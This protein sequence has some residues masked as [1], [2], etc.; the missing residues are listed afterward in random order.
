MLAQDTIRTMILSHPDVRGHANGALVRCIEACGACAQACISCADAC[1]GEERV[2]Q[3]RQCIRVDLD[4]ADV[5]TATAAF[6]IR[7]T[8][9]NE[10][11]VHAMLET[12]A[13][14]CRTC[15][16]ECER[17]SRHHVHCRVCAEACRQCEQ[18]C[19]EAMRTVAH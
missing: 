3:L 10:A 18:A 2:T 11:V 7:R 17:H 1:L 15:A 19:R 12:C 14:A 6:A 16:E 4:C 13:L 5:C 8:G 9:A